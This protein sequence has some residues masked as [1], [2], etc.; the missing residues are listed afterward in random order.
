MRLVKINGLLRNF[1]S[2]FHTL[3]KFKLLHIKIIQKIL[4]KIFQ[5]VTV[6][7]SIHAAVEI[8]NSKLVIFEISDFKML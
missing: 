8:F 5:L 3:L 7:W 1:S 2:I 6:I 4:I